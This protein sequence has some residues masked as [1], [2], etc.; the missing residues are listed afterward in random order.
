MLL[1]NCF[2]RKDQIDFGTKADFENVTILML[3]YMMYNFIWSVILIPVDKL[4]LICIRNVRNNV[5]LLKNCFK[6]IGQLDFA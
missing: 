3:V 4:M 1:K 6:Q 2:K 5:Y